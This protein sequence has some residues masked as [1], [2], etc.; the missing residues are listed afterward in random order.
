M[1]EQDFIQ[2]EAELRNLSGFIGAPDLTEER[3]YRQ[4]D[5][6]E[7]FE[8]PMPPRGRVL[9]Q[10]DALDRFLSLY[11]GAVYQNAM[12]KIRG[13]LE[14]SPPRPGISN[15]PTHAVVVT[16]NQLASD[17]ESFDL[18]TLPD[19]TDLRQQLRNLRAQ[20]SEA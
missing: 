16:P 11:D 19:L 15:F 10:L 14:E 8:Y 4:R 3:Y 9:A 12:E 6:F 17:E 18:R 1:E 20:L 5:G 7:G 13:L 2:I